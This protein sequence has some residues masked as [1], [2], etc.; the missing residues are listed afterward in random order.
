MEIKLKLTSWNANRL[1]KYSL[2]AFILRQDIDI[3]LVSETHF[4]NKSYLRV[5]EYILY[6]TMHPDGKAHGKI[7]IIIK[8]SITKLIN[9][10]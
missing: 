10:K 2:E 5:P 4:T 7:A 1:A 9:I 6:H 8:S 3:L